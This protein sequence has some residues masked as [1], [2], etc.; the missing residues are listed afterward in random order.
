MLVLYSATVFLSAF[1]IFLVQPMIGKMILP[2][3]GGAPA[4]W[5]SCL[6]F[7][8]AL[9]L[10]GYGY[11]HFS[12]R[13]L[14][15]YRQALTHL[16][17]MVGALIL[18]PISF[19]RAA[20]VPE[21]PSLWLI[22]RLFKSAGLPFFVLTALS[23]LLQFWF[24]RTGHQKADNPYFLFAASNLG[25]F[26]ALLLYPTLV[27]PSFDLAVQA[28]IW[29]GGFA[30]LIVMLVACRLTVK[31]ETADTAEI[32]STDQ[33][34][35]YETMLKWLVAALFPSALLLAATQFIT[36][37]IS[38][39]PLLWIIPL[40]IYLLT[41][42]MAFSTWNLA[43]AHIKKLFF[44]AVMVFPVAYYKLNTNL[45]VAAPLHLA[46][47]F[48]I[49]LY[50]HT[51][52]ARNR[53]SV[54]HLTLFYANISLGGAVGSL[55][56]SFIAPLLFT[57]SAEYPILII[58][59]C[60]LTRHFTLA[61]AADKT[62]ERPDE[63]L[64]LTVIMGTYAA[65]MFAAI[66][67]I[68]F[69]KFLQHNAHNIGINPEIG[70]LRTTVLFL[71]EKQNSCKT[72]AMIL[73]TILP[74]LTLRKLPRINL[75]MFTMVCLVLTTIWQTGNAPI[76]LCSMRNF[77]GIKDVRLSIEDQM[78]SLIYGSTVHGRQSLNLESMFDPLDYYHRNGP[79]GSAFRQLFSHKPDLKAGI[80]GLGIGSLLAYSKPGNEFTFYEIDPQVIKIANN[81]DYFSYLA[82]FKGR[83]R[84]VCGDGRRMIEKS[85]EAYYDMIF[86]DAFSSDSIPVHLMTLEAMR[87]YF[88]RLKPDGVIVINI[89][90][91]YLDLKPMLAALANQ[92]SLYGLYSLDRVFDQN[93]PGN[94]GRSVT[95]YVVLTESLQVAT[96]LKKCEYIDWQNLRN[97]IAAGKVW[98]DSYSSLYSLLQPFRR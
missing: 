86:L 4:A 26:A 98:T 37:D 20:T 54:R 77:F 11:A 46:I 81:T 97:N 80:L 40:A 75:A 94:F 68:G 87:M 25:S 32:E 63:S 60:Y 88:S 3:V 79:V 78:V 89:A 13:R 39:V 48:T 51:Y 17:L 38:P 1:L 82:T 15:L 59:S 24:S 53:P 95:E 55:L 83:S 35:S 64:V 30:L 73:V 84:I 19:D 58:L 29:S 36:A 57:S 21:D 70:F 72:L 62:E 91:R 69:A 43:P 22:V 18:L 96:E 50:C 76:K 65:A 93:D 14:G 6:F 42:V 8:Q 74:L 41:Y 85:Q 61:E 5:N 31:S 52:L 34:P 90:N 7:F 71:I 23:P 56:I 10:A 67:S 33:A 9:M 49:S 27:E 28:K 12:L 2:L 44:A 66:E 45:W 47:L 92:L 16:L